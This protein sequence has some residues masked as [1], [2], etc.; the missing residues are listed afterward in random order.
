MYCDLGQVS[1]YECPGECSE[2]TCMSCI[3]WVLAWGS[4]MAVEVIPGEFLA[5]T[6]EKVLR[7]C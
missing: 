4:N 3:T 2:T 1:G 6:H 7:R 5:M